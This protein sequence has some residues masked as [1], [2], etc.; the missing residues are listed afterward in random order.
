MIVIKS[1]LKTV[2][3]ILPVRSICLGVLFLSLLFSCSK[4]LEEASLDPSLGALGEEEIELKRA[5]KALPIQGVELQ[6]EIA[7][8][9]TP[10]EVGVDSKFSPHHGLY[11][12]SSLRGSRIEFTGSKLTGRHRGGFAQFS[13]SF[14]LENGQLSTKGPHT[15]RIL[16]E[17]LYS[18]NNKLT[19]HLLSKD[20]FGAEIFPTAEFI[21]TE[22]VALKGKDSAYRLRGSLQLHGVSREIELLA[23]LSVLSDK[24]LIQS[25]F[26]IDRRDF[27]I[28]YPGLADDLIR[29]EVVIHLKLVGYFAEKQWTGTSRS[30]YEVATS[31]VDLLSQK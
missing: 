28:S 27:K 17:S 9:V 8:A 2:S 6:K 16:I 3:V 24:V 19:Q 14:I 7:E 4:E 22:A 12:I 5:D 29:N 25:E 15:L 30:I 23:Q 26:S 11:N 13:G 31:E 1:F 21:L 20:F 10:Y 18:D